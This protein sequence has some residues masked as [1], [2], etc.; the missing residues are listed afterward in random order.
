MSARILSAALVTAA[1]AVSAS[2]ASAAYLSQ[3]FE[4]APTG[5]VV[6]PA[7]GT[8]YVSGRIDVVGSSTT[9]AHPF[10]DPGNGSQSLLV[11][12]NADPNSANVSF[13]GA[14]AITSGTFSTDFYFTNDI[15]W[16]PSYAEFRIGNSTITSGSDLG[17]WLAIN[18]S[19]GLVN[20]GGQGALDQSI[21]F[22]APHKLVISFDTTAGTKGQWSGTLDG[23]QL[24]SGSGTNSVFD[25][26]SAQTSVQ[27]FGLSAGHSTNTTS[28]VFV[29]NLMVVVPE[30]ATLGLLAVGS[31][32][33]LLRPRRRRL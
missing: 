24:T 3:D 14:S 32:L 31:G 10:T 17:V 6:P 4:S 23:V 21:T 12:D 27:S 7:L 29:D 16:S 8:N 22:N 15:T 9:P 28:R 25:F 20:Y 11:E 33:A 5:A 19:G 1:L 26:N 30:P 13:Q 2:S 18:G